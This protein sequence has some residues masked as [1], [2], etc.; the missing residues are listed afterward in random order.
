MIKKITVTGPFRKRDSMCCPAKL[1][2]S[3]HLE[4]WKMTLKACLIKDRFLIFFFVQALF[5][6]QK[7]LTIEVKAKIAMTSKFWFY[8]I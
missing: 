2:S 5:H 8:Y 1:H 4:I 6:S 3:S 7:I